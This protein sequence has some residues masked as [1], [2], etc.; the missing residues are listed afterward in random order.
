MC[1]FKCSNTLKN[2]KLAITPKLSL[3]MT[4]EGFFYYSHIKIEDAGGAPLGYFIYF[5]YILYASF[6]SMRQSHY[7]VTTLLYSFWYYGYT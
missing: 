7:L 4:N 6:V 2:D 5:L 3:K 1:C